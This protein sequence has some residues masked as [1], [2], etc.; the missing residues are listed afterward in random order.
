M[1]PFW[2][3][4]WAASEAPES[5]VESRSAGTWAVRH[6]SLVLLFVSIMSVPAVGYSLRYL[7]PAGARVGD[8]LRDYATAATLACGV[9]LVM[10]R[11]RV[12]QR[13]VER[14]NQGVRLLATAC[15]QAGEL[16]VILR[17][18]RIEY[19]NDAFCRACGYS[20][21]DVERPS[22]ST[23]LGPES[24]ARL[25][26]LTESLRAQRT[27]R[28]TAAIARKDGSI[29]QAACVVTPL[30]NG[31]GQI[32]HIVAVIR[33]TT[34][35]ERLREHLVRGERLS[36]IGEFVSGVAHELNNPLQ[37]LIGTLELMLSETHTPEVHADL[38]RAQ[39]EAWRAGRIVRNL[40]T[41]IRRAPAERLLV[42]LNDIVQSTVDV[43][44][45]ELGIAGID[46]RRW[47][48]AGTRRWA[49]R[50]SRRDS[51]GDPEPRRKR[52]AGDVGRA[53]TRRV[54]RADVS[55]ARL[56]RRRGQRR[57]SGDSAG[58]GG[59][60]LRT[61]LHHTIVGCG[62]RSRA[63]A[64]V[65]H[66]EGSWRRSRGRSAPE[67]RVLPS[68]T[69]RRR[70]PRARIHSLQESACAVK[71]AIIPGDGIGVEVTAEAVK[72]I[73]AVTDVFGHP[74]ELTTLPWSADYYLQTGI[75]IPP[76][77]YAML[78]DDFDA[79]FIGALGD[80][81]VPDNRHARDILLGTRFE[82][83]LYVNYRPVRLLHET[84]CPLKHRTPADVDFVV[85]R[86]NTEGR[87]MSTSVAASSPAPTTKSPSRRS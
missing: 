8:R 20:R 30:V 36:A 85:F 74:V 34:E 44:A 21:E 55:R 78:R 46:A 5:P 52:P 1:L 18:N 67:G 65:R 84:L 29:F 25:P 27:V 19:A 6:S 14:A 82:L 42:D 70:L 9:G 59:A 17:Q 64:V 38:E 77:G 24:I 86:E 39:T 40:L 63:F 22:P 33:D 60:N 83:D 47:T 37:S 49:L 41:F 13:G 69:C 12:E 62:S 72:V 68:L 61:V 48:S 4:A 16:I 3:A 45:Y 31:V 2:F 66:R 26:T 23:L 32:T 71:I 56:R 53:W 43:R 51:A 11:L 87:S 28:T 54:V 15:E 7:M 79:V 58:A 80:P 76:N 35:E 50:E 81:R 57:W 10:I 75:T 73:C